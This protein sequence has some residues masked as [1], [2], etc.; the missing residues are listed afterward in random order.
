MQ[1]AR[2]RDLPD[3]VLTLI[4]ARDMVELETK[5]RSEVI[6]QSIV[7][8]LLIHTETARYRSSWHSKSMPIWHQFVRFVS[9]IIST[10]AVTG[11]WAKSGVVFGLI[12]LLLS[13][14]VNGVAL[15]R[16]HAAG[17]ESEQI[18][19]E[20]QLTRYLADDVLAEDRQQILDRLF[21]SLDSPKQEDSN[22]ESNTDQPVEYSEIQ[23]QIFDQFL[24]LIQ[25][26]SS[27]S[28]R[29]LVAQLRDPLKP[30]PTLLAQPEFANAI[31]D[32]LL[33]QSDAEIETLDSSQ[34]QSS[35]KQ[36]SS[37]GNQTSARKQTRAASVLDLS[38]AEEALR[39]P[40]L[41]HLRP[42]TFELVDVLGR[43]P[44]YLPAY[45]SIMDR[46]IDF[47]TDKDSPNYPRLTA[48]AILATQHDRAAHNALLRLIDPQLTL[49]RE[50]LNPTLV[51]AIEYALRQI[52]VLDAAA[53]ID[54][55][56]YNRQN[57]RLREREWAANVFFRLSQRQRV[58]QAEDDARQTKLLNTLGN[59]YRTLPD[60]QRGNLII[61][62]LADN[63]PAIRARAVQ[64]TLR[65][66]ID[67]QPIDDSVK[68]ALRELLADPQVDIRHEA[69]RLLYDMVDEP[70]ATIAMKRFTQRLERDP[71]IIKTYLRMFERFPQPEAVPMALAVLGQ[72]ELSNEA[73]G[74]IAAALDRGLLNEQL[75]PAATSAVRNTIND[76]GPKPR[77]VQLLGKLGNE[78]DWKQLENWIRKNP[79]ELDEPTL[80]A[81]VDAW[82]D[83][84]RSL[85]PLAEASSHPIIADMLWRA[86]ATRQRMTSGEADAVLSALLNQPD[87]LLTFTNGAVITDSQQAFIKALRFASPEN[88]MP[89]LRVIAGQLEVSP[90]SIPF[91]EQ[92]F[93]QLLTDSV[94]LDVAEQQELALMLGQFRL[95]VGN[96]ESALTSFETFEQ[97]A[98]NV[99]IE[100]NQLRA[101]SQGK[102]TAHLGLNQFQEAIDAL[103]G[104]LV[105]SFSV[106]NNPSETIP[107]LPKRDDPL[108]E[109]FFSHAVRLAEAD[110]DDSAIALLELL[111]SRLGS[112]PHT[113]VKERLNRI[114]AEVS[115]ANA[116]AV[117]PEPSEPEASEPEPGDTE[118]SNSEPAEPENPESNAS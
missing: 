25:A 70:S 110:Q 97:L 72:T 54:W 2:T 52:A 117:E 83:A 28:R 40:F 78:Q 3:L 68:T 109:L 58:Q 30:I 88:V 4:S 32:Q 75:Q 16:T 49:T 33:N 1:W 76:M 35:S 81:V 77:L 101:I 108:F 94:K 67:Q 13:T 8:N 12:Y 82:V 39:N 93:S 100:P 95:K 29:V 115:G 113:A 79:S 91:V 23:R 18:D 112:D 44:L 64:L 38:Q 107:T 59:L 66:L 37:N 85:I 104:F 19:L 45:R 80:R 48:I 90:R 102:V 14:L 73:A 63:D 47:A 15:Q 10:S 22:G 17:L 56:E 99:S 27:P 50:S 57:K 42:S 118:P 62:M 86:V 36:S 84:K 11:R 116:P 111:D 114:L 55:S 69:T 105:S 53:P 6:L 43:M 34:G 92:V 96:F 21:A 89:S 65:R 26:E 46:V 103:H 71:R 74:F 31:V 24:A 61:E 106:E 9:A 20:Q 51:K 60:A 98:E 5:T 41:T 7:N 87:A